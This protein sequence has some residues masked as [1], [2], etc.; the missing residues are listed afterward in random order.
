MTYLSPA[1]SA[2]DRVKDW[3]VL[4]ESI[5]SCLAALRVF[6]RSRGDTALEVLALRQQLAVLKRKRRRPQLDRLDRVFWT[7]LRREGIVARP[8]GCRRRAGG[9]LAVEANSLE[10][11]ET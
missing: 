9:K 7:V 8:A 1:E 3:F 2:L 4:V 11:A 10:C 6:I 5:P